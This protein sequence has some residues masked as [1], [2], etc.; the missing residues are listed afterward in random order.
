MNTWALWLHLQVSR[1]HHTVMGL[2]DKP[3]PVAL[4]LR[5]QF[6]GTA[7]FTSDNPMVDRYCESVHGPYPAQRVQAARQDTD[8]MGEA[9]QFAVIVK[10]TM[11]EMMRFFESTMTAIAAKSAAAVLKKHERET[12]AENCQQALHAPPKPVQ[13]SARRDSGRRDRPAP[14]PLTPQ[15][16]E[17]LLPPS[18][19]TAVT[20][21]HH[22]SPSPLRFVSSRS[23]RRAASRS[24]QSGNDAPATQVQPSTPPLTSPPSMPPAVTPSHHLPP[25]SQRRVSH[26]L[27]VRATSQS[28]RS[29]DES[30][31][32][33]GGVDGQVPSRQHEPLP[34]HKVTGESRNALPGQLCNSDKVTEMAETCSAVEF[35]QYWMGSVYGNP[36]ITWKSDGQQRLLFSTYGGPDHGKDILAIIPT[37]GGKSCI[38]DIPPQTFN[39]AMTTVIIVPFV[40]LEEQIVMRFSDWNVSCRRWTGDSSGSNFGGIPQ[41]IVVSADKVKKE[42]FMT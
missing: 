21:H 27:Q 22:P 2:G 11:S 10:D 13:S 32:M 28:E 31:D 23:Q 9:E 8:R 24:E 38:Y 39:A 33:S 3:P 5:G 19:P 7:M 26:R 40:A 34:H 4:F 29:G 1:S 15:A 18:V 17:F 6:T 36:E 30:S 42:S 37:G 16:R 20:Q 41:V 14:P 12:R 25:S 35:V